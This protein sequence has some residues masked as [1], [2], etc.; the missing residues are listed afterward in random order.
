MC[1]T[2]PEACSGWTSI[3]G[4]RGG[5]GR[6]HGPTLAD[7][8]QEFLGRRVER[9]PVQEAADDNHRMRPH[10]VDYRV[11]PKF[12]ELVGTDHRVVVTTP[13][14]IDARFEFNEIVNVGSIFNCPIHPAANAAQRESAL[15]IA[16]SHLFKRCQHPILIKMAVPKIC[17]GVDL[18]LQL[19]T[20]LGKRWV[21]PGCGQPLQMIPTLIRIDDVNSFV[22]TLETIPNERKQYAILF[23]VAIEKC[24]DM[25]Y[26]AELGTGKGNRCC[27]LFHAVFLPWR[28]PATQVS[29]LAAH[30]PVHLISGGSPT[31]PANT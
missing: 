8:A 27:G 25:T 20:L 21:D 29:R 1:W 23:V 30:P 19:P 24:A 18:K 22:A 31:N 5:R 28:S 12:A 2:S 10:D 16:A 6:P 26:F 7:L 14:I 3:L 4:S 13:H 15:G 17:F 11:A 9:I